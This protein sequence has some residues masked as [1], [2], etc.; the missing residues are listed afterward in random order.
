MPP[1][2]LHIIKPFCSNA[3]IIICIFSVSFHL[4]VQLSPKKQLALT[5]TDRVHGYPGNQHHGPHMTPLQR[6]STSF[7]EIN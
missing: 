1:S 5:C 3:Y 2:W 4:I 6:A 7:Q